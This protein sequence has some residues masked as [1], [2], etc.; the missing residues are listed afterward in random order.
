M[1][2]TLH[3]A[4]FLSIRFTRESGEK[5]AMVELEMSHNKDIWG[6][7][8][9]MWTK[10]KDAGVKPSFASTLNL[11]QSSV[12]LFLVSLYVPTFFHKVH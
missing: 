5:L 8:I 10:K 6:V 9:F 12:Q 7:F 4:L 3:F 11:W 2:I 1:V